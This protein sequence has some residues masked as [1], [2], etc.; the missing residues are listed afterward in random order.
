[1][2]DVPQF[3]AKKNARYGDAFLLLLEINYADG[4]FLRWA[5]IDGRLEPSIEFE[6]ETWT[7][8]GIG[9]PQ[10]SQ[11]SRAEI[12][13]F[14]IPIANP[15]RAMQSILHNYIIE[16]KTGRLIT[17]DR[18]HLDDPTAKAEEWFTVEI[19][20]ATAKVVTLTCKGVRFNPRVA[21]IPSQ[22]MTRREYPGLLGINRSRYM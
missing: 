1:M 9:I 21:R 8:F 18:D 11:T 15:D 16:G 7:A 22:T 19:V 4:E 3:V 2:L 20:S 13:T 6:G 10:R 17:A 5:K 12:P 14:E